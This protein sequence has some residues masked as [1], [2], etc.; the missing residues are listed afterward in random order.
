[1]VEYLQTT[2]QCGPLHWDSGDY[3]EPIRSQITDYVTGND[4][5]YNHYFYDSYA[6]YGMVFG[7]P[8]ITS[9]IYNRD[10]S[11][12]FSDNRVKAWH[13]A[14]NGELTDRLSYVVKGSYRE[15]WGTYYKPIYPK[16]HSF[17]ALIQGCYDLRPWTFSAAY[18]FDSGNIYGNGST[19]DFKISYHGKIL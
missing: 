8:L 10:G 9:P 1:V 12:G 7:N 16:R 3:P 17:D 19:F 11:T 2:N 18:A 4:N 5:Y 6:H 13:V 15:G 14:V